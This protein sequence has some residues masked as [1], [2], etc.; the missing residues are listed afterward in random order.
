MLLLHLSQCGHHRVSQRQN[1][2][3]YDYSKSDK[4][5]EIVWPFSVGV[6]PFK[7]ARDATA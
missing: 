6:S 3:D 5:D 7:K 2:S 1:N 4:L